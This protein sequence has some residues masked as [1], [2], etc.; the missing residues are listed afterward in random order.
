MRSE[1]SLDVASFISLSPFDVAASFEVEF[2]SF[3]SEA[4]TVLA[5]SLVFGSSAATCSSTF[6]S[7]ESIPACARTAPEALVDS[8]GLT[9]LS[10]S[11]EV[12]AMLVK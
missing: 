7:V 4:V 11:F 12:S 3:E 9:V 5:R 10:T 2:S 8:S 1:V 6:E